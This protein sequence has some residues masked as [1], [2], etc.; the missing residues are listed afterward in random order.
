VRLE[1]WCAC[2]DR[3]GVPT[4]LDLDS[5]TFARIAPLSRGVVKVEVRW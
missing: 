4:L 3:H 1:D 2:G 5:R